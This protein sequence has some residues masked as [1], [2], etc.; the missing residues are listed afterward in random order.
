M[1]LALHRSAVRSLWPS[2]AESASSLGAP[3]PSIL[4]TVDLAWGC[5]V[6]AALDVAIP[7]GLVCF[8]AT[9]DA[10]RRPR[11]NVGALGRHTRCPRA[12]CPRRTGYGDAA[13]HLRWSVP[14]R[15]GS[16]YRSV[17]AA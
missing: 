4:T 17:D 14:G 6:W 15:S 8:G 12:T 11:L 13:S 3:S 5:N 1:L 9:P 2:R 16:E 7:S 10:R